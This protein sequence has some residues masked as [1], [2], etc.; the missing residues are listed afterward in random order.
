[1]KITSKSENETINLGSRLAG[2]LAD[3]DILF[4]KGDLG[5]GKTV[6]ARA[7][8]RAICHNNKLE[9]PS[10]TFT[11]VQTYETDLAP[12]WH[13]DLYRLDTPEEIYEIGWEEALTEGILII[14]WPEKLAHL[15][16]EDR[17]DIVLE[18]SANNKN[19]TI[20]VEPK[21]TLKNRNITD[22]LLS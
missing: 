18:R 11:L 22:A 4:L 17:I 14:E 7:I 13:F 21:G 19:R 12:V 8:I 3:G 1:M 15:A 9:I 16:P 20:L 10:P 2:K 5:C 6:L